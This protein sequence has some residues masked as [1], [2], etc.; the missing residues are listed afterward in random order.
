MRTVKVSF[1]ADIFD[2]LTHEADARCKTRSEYV[3]DATIAYMTKYPAKGPIADLVRSRAVD[4]K[5]LGPES[6]SQS[7]MEVD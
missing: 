7:S 3:R 1:P 2:R 5:N 6:N 4:P